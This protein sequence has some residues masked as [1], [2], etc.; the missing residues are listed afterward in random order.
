M[1]LSPLK[2]G[3]IGDIADSLAGD[4]DAAMIEEWNRVK[5]VPLPNDPEIAKDRQLIFVAVARGML[6]YLERREDRIGTTTEDGDG[7]HSHQLEFSWE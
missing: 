1:A 6:N 3:R 7:N 4:M 5:D 2:A